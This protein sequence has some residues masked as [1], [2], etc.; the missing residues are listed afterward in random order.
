MA[1]IKYHDGGKSAPILN[2]GIITPSILQV[3]R[4]KCELFFDVR[5]IDDADRVK[6]ILASFCSLNIVNWVNENEDAL[7]A[8]S[9]ADFISQLKKTALTPGWDTAI[10]RTMIN[11]KQPKSESFSKWMN[12]IRGANFSL[13]DTRFHK[14]AA[15]LR[16]HLENLI[17]DDL[18]DYLGSLTK[19]ERDRV[20]AI[21][22]LQEW[23]RE[24]MEI[25][26]TMARNR[27]RNLDLIEEAV[28]RQRTSYQSYRQLPNRG[29]P[30][31]VAALT[32]A[33]RGAAPNAT[34][35]NSLVRSKTDIPPG[36]RFP[37][38][39][40]ERDLL[41]ENKGCRVCGYRA[42]GQSHQRRL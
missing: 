15:S 10:F 2:D 5:K 38:K 30:S 11:I 14:D 27:K 33:P 9:W 13:S 16:A 40:S 32:S 41:R 31:S 17:S 42:S 7:K 21:N 4:K 19:N 29:Q 28:K 37:P 26:D 39:L 23:L 20:E 22:D 6:S 12:G 18:A 1:T 8:L 34:R 25:D 35:F 36:Y 3:W 24:M